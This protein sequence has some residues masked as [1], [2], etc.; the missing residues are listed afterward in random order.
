MGRL[1]EKLFYAGA[2][3]LEFIFILIV[4]SIPIGLLGIVGLLIYK[5]VW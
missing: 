3:I 5:A 4:A 1:I 2:A